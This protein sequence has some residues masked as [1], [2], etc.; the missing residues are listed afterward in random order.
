[1]IVIE[2]YNWLSAHLDDPDV[3]V[4]DARG[5][6]LYRFG[7][8]ENALPIGIESLISVAD[9]GANLVVD[10]ETAEE[11]FT[12]RRIDKSKAVVVYGENIDPSGARVVW[13]L[14]YYGHTNVKL[15]EIGFN[16]WMKAGLATSKQIPTCTAPNDV[17]FSSRIDSSIRADEQTIKDKMERGQTIIVDAR[18]SQEH[19]QARIPGSVLH[20]WEEGIGNNGKMIKDRDEL[21]REFENKGITKN[22]EVVCYCHSGTRASHTYLQLR[23]AGYNNVRLYDGS[24]ID[25][26]QRRNPLR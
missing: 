1:M 5:N 3:I 7:H 22:K 2:D 12:K 6:M 21:I 25:W 8:I 18:T 10:S 16:E 26:A 11:V 13:T 24:I 19:F 23:E 15:L 14:L 17:H 20:N 4:L 9:N